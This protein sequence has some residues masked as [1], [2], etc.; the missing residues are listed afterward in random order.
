MSGKDRGKQGKLLKVDY[1]KGKVLV[2]GLNVFKKHKRPSRQGEKGEV[3]EV[4]RLL[5]AS[6]VLPVCSS[7]NQPTRVGYKIE[8]GAKSRYCKKCKAIF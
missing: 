7:C 5:E 1:K 8:G 2:E 3:V 4:S 6:N